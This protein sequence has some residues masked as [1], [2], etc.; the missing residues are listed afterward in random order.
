MASIIQKEDKLHE[1]ALK[2]TRNDQEKS[3]TMVTKYFMYAWK[4]LNECTY[5]TIVV[6]HSE[7]MSKN[8][9]KNGVKT[10]KGEH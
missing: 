10:S 7:R 8:I 5:I 9:P 2:N 1:G 4:N 6:Y 3:F